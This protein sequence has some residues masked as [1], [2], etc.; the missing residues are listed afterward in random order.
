[1]NPRTTS[2]VAERERESFSESGVFRERERER[3]RGRALDCGGR[4]RIYF[5]DDGFMGWLRKTRLFS[6]PLDQTVRVCSPPLDL[7]HN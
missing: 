1:M 6:K 4:G 3:E 5:E 7:S 2:G